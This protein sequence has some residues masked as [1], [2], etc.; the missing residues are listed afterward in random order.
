MVEERWADTPAGVEAHKWVDHYVRGMIDAFTARQL[1]VVR[2]CTV[3]GFVAG[4]LSDLGVREDVMQRTIELAE[5]AHTCL[6]REPVDQVGARS[7]VRAIGRL[8]NVDL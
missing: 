1:K 8:W 5:M 7:A 6:N 4:G 2:D 3:P